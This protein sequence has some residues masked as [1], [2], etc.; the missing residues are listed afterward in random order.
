MCY[1]VYMDAINALNLLSS[2]MGLEAAGEHNPRPRFSDKGTRGPV[3]VSRAQLPGGGNIRLLKTLLSSYCKHNCRYCPYRAGRD[4]PRA[5]FSPEEF[6]R[7]FFSLHKSGAVDGIFLSSAVPHHPAA[8]QD[9]LIDTAAILRRKY[10]YRGY[11]HLK[12]MPGAEKSQ[13][14]AAMNL[15]DRLSVNLEAPNRAALNQLAPEKRFK[16][17]LLTPLTWIEQIRRNA[18]PVSSWNQRWPSTTTQFVVGAAGES[19]QDLLATTQHLHQET[20]L[21]RAYF[22]SFSPI[23]GTPLENQPPSPPLREFRLYQASY[24]LS[25]YGFSLDELPFSEEGNLP[26]DQDPKLAWAE[27][28]LQFNPLEINQAPRSSLLRIPGIGPLGAQKILQARRQS[29]ITN[30]EQLSSLGIDAN[31]CRSYILLQGKLPPSQPK[32][33]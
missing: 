26:P 1:N 6:A 9:Q 2:Q 10:Q 11:L 22:S 18:E 15:A 19:D 12:I 8:I 33:L 25:S 16:E 24:L 5:A 14:A 20:G 30:L 23:R 31:R 29:P 13:V 3:T 32:L 17:D 21:T 7:L 28:H 4:T 27:Q